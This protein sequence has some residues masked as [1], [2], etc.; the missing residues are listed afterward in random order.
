MTDYQK[1][2][3]E[4]IEKKI[5]EAQELVSA[6]PS[7][8]ELAQEE[9]E[10]LEEEKIALTHPRGE[11]LTSPGSHPGGEPTSPSVILEIRSAAGG[12][13]AGLFAADLLRMYQ[14]FAVN[15]RWQFEELDCTEGGL[16][17]IK[18]VIVKISGKN[19]FEKL[20]HESGVHRV[21]RVPVTE[22][23]GRI[24]TSTATVAILPEVPP[25]QVIIDPADIEFEAFRSGGHGGQNV[26]KVSTAVRIKHKPTGIVVKAQTERSQGQNREI[27]MGI[28]RSKIYQLEEE[29]QSS[30]LSSQ[31]SAQL[32]TR[33]RSE[34]IRTYNYPQNRVTDHRIN[35]S[36]HNLEEIMNGKLEKLIEALNV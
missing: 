24:H 6:D 5:K 20:Q 10:K 3:I 29:K 36:W 19:V 34:K 27:A 8:A 2:Q 23:S 31:R 12:D 18:T 21:Q 17:N 15:N 14:K 32:G 33:D 35:K 11:V 9:I 28:L 16:G 22:S 1:Q 25:T 4:N 26:N 7:M 30:Q 13:E